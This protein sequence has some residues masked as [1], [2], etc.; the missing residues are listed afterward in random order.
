MDRS[1]YNQ[2]FGQ[3]SELFKFKIK[4][5]KYHDGKN[6]KLQATEIKVLGKLIRACQ[7]SNL[8]SSYP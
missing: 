2:S 4:T 5:K 6:E 1:R 3:I 8:E 7:E